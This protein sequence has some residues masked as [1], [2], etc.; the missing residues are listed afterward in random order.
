MAQGPDSRTS[1][2]PLAEAA[3]AL[4]ISRLKLR[5]AIAKGV[6]PARRDNE[7]R[8]R[9]DLDSGPAD[10]A[11]ALSGAPVKPEALMEALFDEIEELQGDL[12]ASNASVETLAALALRQGDAL[13]RVTTALEAATRD[14][15]RLGALADRALAAAEEASGRATILQ[16]TTDRA[17]GLLDHAAASIEHMKSEVDRL[18]SDSGAKQAAHADQL[19]RL[20]T[21]SEQA[22]EKAS[23][24]RRAPSLIARVLGAG[25]RT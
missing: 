4:G 25:R 6:I 11:T 22:L 21:L 7:G 23:G 5:E 13:D 1:F 3:T 10:L 14:R 15:D 18:T 16:G 8:L 24:A 12:E 9:V 17:L 2:L 20:F 19:D